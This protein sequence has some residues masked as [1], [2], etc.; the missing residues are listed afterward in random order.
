[1]KSLISLLIIAATLSVASLGLANNDAEWTNVYGFGG[2]G[3]DIVYDVHVD[4]DGNAITVGTFTGSMRVA[5]TDHVSAGN[6][7]IIV[8]KQSSHGDVLWS[9]SGGGSGYDYA[10]SVT[11][12]N[13]GNIY[14]GGAFSN[15]AKIGDKELTAFGQ[16]DAYVMK[17]NRDGKVDWI[18]QFGGIGLDIVSSV[19]IDNNG[20]L[21]VAGWFNDEVAFGTHVLKSAGVAD[22]FVAQMGT[23]GSVEWAKSVG[24]NGTVNV[25]SV[26][27]DQNNN[28]IIAGQFAETMNVQGTQK[29]STGTHDAYIATF[30]DKGTLQWTDFLSGAGNQIVYDIT[31]DA[32]NNIVVSGYFSHNINIGSTELLSNGYD[33]AF[34][35]HYSAD[36]SV[37]WAVGAGGNN[38]DYGRGIVADEDGTY[39]MIGYFYGSATFGEFTLNAHGGNFDYDGYLAR[40]SADGE[41]I[42]AEVLGGDR[43]DFLT[44]ITK[45]GNRG[46]IAYGYFYDEFKAGSKSVASAGSSDLLIAH[47]GSDAPVRE[48]AAHA[49]YEVVNDSLIV[50]I[51][52]EDADDLYYFS[53]EANFDN[54]VLSFGRV[55]KGDMMGSDAL[56]ISGTVEDGRGIS[57]GKTN[58][59]GVSGAGKV[60]ELAFGIKDI[61]AGL[62]TELVFQNLIA[63]NSSMEPLPV[64]SL[65]IVPVTIDAAFAVW[66]GDANNDGVVDERDVLALGKHWGATGEARSNSS[67]SWAPQHGSPWDNYE[68]TFADTDGDGNVDHN[69]L[70]AISHN[71]GKTRSEGVETQLLAMNSDTDHG[72]VLGQLRKGESVV[73][74][75][76]ANQTRRVLGMS[77]RF[78]VNGVSQ[79]AYKIHPV[80]LGDWASEMQASQDVLKLNREQDGFAALAIMQTSNAKTY[81]TEPG[82]VVMRVTVEATKDWNSNGFLQ[83]LNVTRLCPVDGYQEMKDDTEMIFA[84]NQDAGFGLS[85][86]MPQNIQLESNYPNPFNPT[87]SIRFGLP[88]DEQ[89]RL[90]VYNT[91]GH[92]VATLVNGT[93][94]GGYHDVSFDASQLASGMYIYRLQAGGVVQT[95]KMTLVK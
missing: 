90:T 55:S 52:V 45:N 86:N 13:N 23:N 54:K 65:L 1:M 84:Q 29:Q 66:P 77:A 8:I 50:S 70:R 4:R 73:Y 80:E 3:M 69:D 16:R 31:V 24:S 68:A 17:L 79:D 71:F 41:F 91:L 34:A 48:L 75:I 5:G 93:M 51:N 60:L 11:T 25:Q 36:G 21:V 76:V 12:D 43:S 61:H 15:I 58:G 33:D 53:M 74:E 32:V 27:V 20:K 56:I 2:S 30:N 47:Y 9:L 83:E 6:T 7:A 22:G 72:Q 87:T 26:A 63:D 39:L 19:T 35:A 38:W 62:D 82:M 81:R 28:Y 67:I 95:K 44:G 64:E 46:H 42:H 40:L 78:Q 57:I 10:Y 89:V 85:D 49:D 92:E 88:Q 37:N 59:A 14:I 94:Q 18:S